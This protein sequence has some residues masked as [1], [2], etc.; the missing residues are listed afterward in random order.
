[1]H[2]DPLG[3]RI[4]EIPVRISYQI[5]DLFSGQLYSSPNKAIEELV[6]NSYDAMARNSF[7]LIDQAAD[8][9]N[10]FVAVWDDGDSM[11]PDGFKDLWN[12]ARKKTRRVGARQQIGKFGI[13]KLATYVIG[14]RITFICKRKG[15]HTVM[16]D[17]SKIESAAEGEASTDARIPV[18]LEVKSL[19]EKEVRELVEPILQ[20]QKGQKNRIE[21][22]G[23][24]APDTWTLVVVD[25][26]K[27]PSK[28]LQV[29]RLRW[30]VSTALPIVPGFQV[31]LNGELVVAS[32][33][34]IPLLKTW[35]I[36][37]NDKIA[38]KLGWSTGTDEPKRPGV[39]VPDESGAVH[40]ISGT[41]E[42]YEDTLTGGKA[43]RLGRSYGFFVMVR[44]R[45]VN[46]ADE[47]FG[48]PELSYQTFYRFRA[49][50]N[51]DH[52]DEF[53]IA[54]RESIRENE[55]IRNVRSYLHEKFNETRKFYEE[56]IEE[57]EAEKSL[58]AKVKRMPSSLVRFPLKHAAE[59]ILTLP[60]KSGYTIVLPPGAEPRTEGLIEAVLSEDL[61]VESPIAVYDLSSAAIKIN[62]QHPV[63]L[64][65]L[66]PTGEVP[67]G[68]QLV[69]LA[70]VMTEAYLYEAGISHEV[71]FEAMRLR[72]RFLR[73]M[74]SRYPVSARYVAVR[75]RESVSER[76]P[77]ENALH[78]A[79]AALG[80]RVIPM[81]GGNEPEGV[82]IAPLG[83]RP[84]DEGANESNPSYRV[85]YEAK[86]TADE[87][88][89]AKD[90]NLAGVIEFKK[91]F[92]ATYTIVVAK[93]F[94]GG[95]EPDSKAVSEAKELGVCLMRAA[96]LA[97]L[98]E[99][100]A[101]RRLSLQRLEELF[102]CRSP[103]EASTWVDKFVA[104]PGQKVDLRRALEIVWKMQEEG[105]ES[106]DVQGIKYYE[107]GRGGPLGEVDKGAIRE[108]FETLNRLV[109]E[110]VDTWGDK[111]AINV[112]PD[113]VA[114][115]V[116]KEVSQLSDPTA[117]KGL[118]EALG[119]H[120]T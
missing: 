4:D 82:A 18:K 39:F 67:P 40:P 17:Y 76:K 96:D 90:L 100:S 74:V 115:H 8:S 22:F 57:E 94:Q 54:N 34:N 75:I 33:E 99:I 89:P 42:L 2:L 55:W 78:L 38:E 103:S 85:V 10:G 28:E 110:I 70:E 79:F 91:R 98:V 93:D 48:L 19:K 72:D 73:E 102:K 50:V 80:F 60:E 71:V 14:R 3:S 12:V 11:T 25:V 117:G 26:L 49:E 32:K 108:W 68:L 30:I 65:Y 81:A 31:F 37:T 114:E 44:R 43:E 24:K 46:N 107:G 61:G 111:V 104:D 69:A 29:G 47:R 62:T 113:K 106:V 53:L 7:V 51:A 120:E 36:G 118:L 86:S 6:C 119:L 64:N 101:V 35:T 23:S 83:T 41:F 56:F 116:Q 77:F 15:Y 20:F 21:P 13:G 105:R 9:K 95:D 16:M 87:R 88:V 97:R 1:M 5:I 59:R 92:A 84:V 27:E 52:L 58:P 109:P 63:I 112:S 66:G 45:L